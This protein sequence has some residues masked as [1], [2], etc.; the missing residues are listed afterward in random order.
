MPTIF[1][2]DTSLEDLGLVLIEGGPSLDGLSV[3]R[4]VQ[5]WPGRA[6][7]LPSP[8]GTVGSRIHRFVTSAPDPTEAARVARLDTI[9]DL[10]TGSVEVR[11]VDRP[12]RC[13]R[14]VARVFTA[15]VPISPRFVNIEPRIV[16][17]VES[18]NAAK[19]EAEPQS[20]ILSTTPTA[21][22]C[23]TLPHGGLIHLTGV[24]AGAIS[25]T[26]RVLYRG[27]SGLTLGELVLLPSLLSGEYLIVDLDAESLTKV[28]TTGVRTDAYSWKTGGAFFRVAPRD[29]ARDLGAWA[30]IEITAGAALYH[31]R[32]VWAN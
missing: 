28:S 2:N 31:F 3:T 10:L 27:I 17:E 14:G 25:T 24:A 7:G 21:I 19:W 20:V 8:Y 6:G 4:A 32:R 26:T 29:C 5:P 1:L 18:H 15:D 11:Y 13:S 22:P 30:T 16:V 23:G 12:S 9:A